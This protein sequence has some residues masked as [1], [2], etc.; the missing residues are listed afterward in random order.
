MTNLYQYFPVA[1]TP[2]QLFY[3]ALQFSA[4]PPILDLNA[5]TLLLYGLNGTNY[6]IEATSNLGA[7]NGWT[8][9]TNFMLTNSFQF[10]G[11]GSPTNSAMFFRAKRP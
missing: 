10:I 1:P 2:P 3:R 8:P 4:D 7:T 6:V 11:I 5:P 9:A